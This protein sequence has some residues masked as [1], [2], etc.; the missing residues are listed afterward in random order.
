MSGK[1]TG[2]RSTQWF[3][4]ADKDGFHHRSWMKNQGLPHDLLTAAR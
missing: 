1:K 4:K 2:T 3:G